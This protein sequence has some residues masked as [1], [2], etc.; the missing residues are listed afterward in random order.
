MNVFLGNMYQG[1][2]LS[3]LTLLLFLLSA[4]GLG[5]LINRY[6]LRFEFR[7]LGTELIVVFA[8]GLNLMALLTLIAGSS[9]VLNAQN[10]LVSM[11]IFAV[12]GC[13]LLV[14]RILQ[15]KLRF[16][17]GNSIF[18]LILLF[19]AVFTLG[20][21]LC[22]PYAWDEM[23][24]HIAVPLRWLNAGFPA[25][26]QDNPYSGF[27]LLPQFMFYLGIHNG[28]IL[29]PRLLS[30]FLYILLLVAVYLYFRSLTL[31]R[32]HLSLFVTLMF[33]FNPLVISMMRATYVEVFIMFNML[34]ALLLIKKEMISAKLIFLCGLLAGSIVAVKLTGVGIAAIIFIFLWAA[35]RKRGSKKK[36]ILFFYFA[37]GGICMALPFYLRS[38]LLV[39]NPFYPFLASWFGGTE[40]DILVAK[41]HYLMGSSH[42]GLKSVLGFFTVF[43][44]IAFDEK[45]FD[46]LTLG[47]GFIVFLVLTVY[48]WRS[49]FCAPKKIWLG[50]V[51]LPVAII[52]YYIFWFM[53]SQQTRFLQPLLFLILI[54]VFYALAEFK[55]RTN[56]NIIMVIIAVCVMNLLFPAVNNHTLGSS[57]W[58]AFRH[59]FLSWKSF[60]EFPDKSFEFLKY[61]SRDP[62]YFEA[63]QA[64]VLKTPVDSKITFLYERRG[65]Y[66]PRSFVI[67]TPYFQPLYNTPVAPSASEFYHSLLDNNM[68]YILLGGSNRN[69][70]ELGGKYLEGKERIMEQISSLISKGKLRVLWGSG[71]YFLC[72]VLAE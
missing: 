49:L 50:K 8:L 53:T 47:W 32:Y 72:Q 36:T 7:S 39:D 23:S 61:A 11:G 43:I 9:G 31:N 48:W 33:V 15:D 3:F 71:D 20:S 60:N 58:M 70:D 59:F 28:G 18:L 57:K 46:G 41:Y 55:F 66:C 37:L 12:P 51:H 38:W 30:W 19:V 35:S 63:M 10:S 29:F 34:A 5:I 42:F 56:R 45:S 54:C 44:L 62:G 14:R 16:I 65:L 40:A 67:A 21:A 24:Y 25:V 2:F 4:F 69:P 27:P 26:F 1:L 52:F 13:F 17:R 22:F 6:I 64:L 68:E